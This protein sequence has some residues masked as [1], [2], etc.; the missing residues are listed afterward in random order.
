MPRRKAPTDI[1][2]ALFE[3]NRVHK[4]QG[5]RQWLCSLLCSWE[6]SPAG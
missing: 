5:V 1:Q 3:V 6:S 4:L 2:P